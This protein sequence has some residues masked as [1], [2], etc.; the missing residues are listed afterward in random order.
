MFST[1]VNANNPETNK[2]Q[3][4][5]SLSYSIDFLEPNLNS[6][7]IYD[8]VFTGISMPGTFGTS[9]EVGGPTIPT[10]A[11]RFVL[12]QGTE[13]MD[14]S[15]TFSDKINV[16]CNEKGVDLE[17]NP[18]VP[19]QKQIPIGSIPPKTI[20]YN[21][22]SYEFDSSVPGKLFDHVKVGYCRGYPIVSFSLYPIEYNPKDSELFYYPRMNID[23]NLIET[24]YTNQYYR[25]LPE[26]NEWVSSL[27]MNPEVIENY[28]PQASL[29]ELYSGGLCN[30][31]DNNGLGYDY[32][33]ITT[34]A[35]VDFV[36]TYN[37]DDLINR[38]ISDGLQATKIT[39]EDIVACSD[40]WDT[41]NALFNDSVFLLN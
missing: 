30:P 10:K 32:V 14:V 38:K 19:Y 13:L 26:D 9:L 17:S 37:W 5:V 11:M 39:V 2:D 16:D 20:S 29:D 35:L 1:V 3:N 33:I 31:S 4:Q 41:S 40:Y 15:I 6:V 27:V 21:L 12:P 18:V 8:E 28:V 23:I 7:C 22:D 25:G 36:E 24:G 34:D